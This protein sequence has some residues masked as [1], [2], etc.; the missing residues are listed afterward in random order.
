MYSGGEA[1]MK[2]LQAGY[3][4]RIAD[5]ETI[6]GSSILLTRDNITVQQSGCSSGEVRPGS[7]QCRGEETG[8]DRVQFE[9]DFCLAW[10][11][12]QFLQNPFT[13]AVRLSPLAEL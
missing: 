12:L 6:T 2:N 13:S 8:Q 5:A 10:Y 11:N 4:L 7:D 1:S 3:R 9:R